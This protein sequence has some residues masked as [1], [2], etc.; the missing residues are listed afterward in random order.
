MTDDQRSATI[1]STSFSPAEVRRR[2]ISALNRP[3]WRGFLLAATCFLVAGLL[4]QI[5][6]GVGAG[7][8]L[9]ISL[10]NA[11]GLFFAI[12]FLLIDTWG[13]RFWLVWLGLGVLALLIAGANPA[14][15]WIAFGL[16]AVFLIIR[17]YQAYRHLTS[18]QRAQA[19]GLGLIILLLLIVL[20]DRG[21]HEDAV[22]PLGLIWNMGEWARDTAI[23]FWAFSLWHLVINMRL[24]FMRLRPKLA[25]SAVL[26]GLV[27]LVLVILLGLLIVFGALGGSRAMRARDLLV[28]WGET[29][30][31]PVTAAGAAAVQ[32]FAWS[33]DGRLSSQGAPDWVPSLAQELVR[34]REK[35]VAVADPV[36][37][38]DADP[39]A[40]ADTTTQ[41]VDR[42]TDATDESEESEGDRQVGV[43]IGDNELPWT[44]ADTTA[45]FLVR[46]QIWLIEV[47][48]I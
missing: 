23:V 6:S 31:T 42:T 17:R 48:G 39:D 20:P 21:D 24:H 29:S 26:L 19:F 44:P 25:A 45:Y 13:R 35:G 12:R 4:G 41:T 3:A 47:Q 22:Y 7:R 27:P 34:V 9:V 18:A 40:A 1:I 32:S 10:G 46:D 11:A 15:R 33:V 5:W 16:S 28:A 14:G 8:A 30:D 2:R 38:A 37:D 43:T 36:A